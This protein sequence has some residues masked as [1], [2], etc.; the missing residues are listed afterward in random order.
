MVGRKDHRLGPATLSFWKVGLRTGRGRGLHTSL[1][2]LTL[3]KSTYSR[4][5]LNG[6]R[7]GASKGEGPSERILGGRGFMLEQ[8]KPAQGW[9]SRNPRLKLVPEPKGLR[10]ATYRMMHM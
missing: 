2:I 4:G 3:L 7:G 5:G 1:R 10:E 9:N 8:L 6:G